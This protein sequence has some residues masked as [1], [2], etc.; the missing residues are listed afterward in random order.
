MNLL[1]FGSLWFIST[2]VL[3]CFG[4]NILILDK[5]SLSARYFKNSSI[6]LV[7]ELPWV[8][9][10]QVSIYQVA[11][12]SHFYRYHVWRHI[13]NTKICEGS[14]NNQMITHSVHFMKITMPAQYHMWLLIKQK[15]P[16][17]QCFFLF[18]H[19]YHKRGVTQNNTHLKH[20]S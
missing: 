9:G 5:T 4:S 19:I 17:I 3:G 13:F 2:V 12:Y 7:R 10:H 6:K 16:K 15:V 14:N 8:T 1:D 20:L 11:V 18:L